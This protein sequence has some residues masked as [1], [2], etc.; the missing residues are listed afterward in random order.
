M[1][2]P[3]SATRH[4]SMSASGSRDRGP[5]QSRLS[6]TGARVPMSRSRLNQRCQMSRKQAANFKGKRVE[7]SPCRPRYLAF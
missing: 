5:L 3:R 6:L 4:P 1:G 2:S 7:P